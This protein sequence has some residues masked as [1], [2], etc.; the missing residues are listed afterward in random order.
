MIEGFYSKTTFFHA[1]VNVK[2]EKIDCIIPGHLLCNIKDY[3]LHVVSMHLALY[4]ACFQFHCH[5][6]MHALT[7]M[8]PITERLE[9][10][11]LVENPVFTVFCMPI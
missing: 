8:L 9:V 6:T 1:T 4:N 7:P 10:L 3:L 2:G 5:V 11:L